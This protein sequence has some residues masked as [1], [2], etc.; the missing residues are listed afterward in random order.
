MPHILIFIMFIYYCLSISSFLESEVVYLDGQSSLL[1]KF[2]S[3]AMRP[4]REVIFLKFK[5]M[6]NSG[7]IFHGKG[8]HGTHIVLELIKGKLVI[9]LSSGKKD[10]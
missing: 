10:L 1:Y 3:G 2:D 8:Q 7:I 6:Q 5:A 9:N 4:I